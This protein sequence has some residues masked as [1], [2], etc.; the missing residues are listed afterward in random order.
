M[1]ELRLHGRGGQGSV[2]ASKLL[3]VAL[4]REG[5]WVQSFPAFGVERRGAPVTAF[6]RFDD[7]PIRL[8]CEI[9]EPDDLIVLDPTLIDAIDVTAG[10]KTGGTILINTEKAPEDYPELLDRFRV[11]TIDASG[12][13]IRHGLGT[14]TQPIVNTALVG[15]FAAEFGLI[16]LESV[17]AAIEDEVPAKQIENFEAAREAFEAVRAA[18]PREVSRV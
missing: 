7:D 9:T 10:L 6:L 5:E 2:I 12:I 14:R 16:S 18:G 17:K 15:A 1:R 3:A 4:F 8:R 11:A 13:A